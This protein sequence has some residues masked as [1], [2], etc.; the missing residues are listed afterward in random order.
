MKNGTFYALQNATV[1][2]EV[3]PGR[4]ER[5]FTASAKSR[6]D[7]GISLLRN[8]YLGQAGDSLT[9]SFTNRFFAC[10]IVT[11]FSR[12]ETRQ[13]EVKKCKNALRI[14]ETD[15]FISRLGPLLMSGSATAR[16]ESP[17]RSRAIALLYSRRKA[18]E[19]INIRFLCIKHAILCA[20]YAVRSPNGTLL[21]NFSQGEILKTEHFNER[22]HRAANSLIML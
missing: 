3:R 9:F 11:W 4:K 7:C 13:L 20:F 22:P 1:P 8:I 14:V 17:F 5:V 15:I 19:C 21:A 10:D 2:A 16:E 12:G 6:A 18:P